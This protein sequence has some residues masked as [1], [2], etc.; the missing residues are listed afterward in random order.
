[1]D[2]GLRLLAT[3]QVAG[4]G[5]GLTGREAPGALVG[6]REILFC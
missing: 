3:G 2:H 4:G 6:E 1:M 5:G